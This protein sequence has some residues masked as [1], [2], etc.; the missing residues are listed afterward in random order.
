MKD[1]I[2]WVTSTRGITIYHRGSVSHT[3]YYVE[4]QMNIRDRD[5]VAFSSKLHEPNNGCI[6]FIQMVYVH[7]FVDELKNILSE[8]YM[9]TDFIPDLIPQGYILRYDCHK[10]ADKILLGDLGTTI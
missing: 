4:I 3:D 1:D 10:I 9:R 5:L 2:E 6:F 8:E 7:R